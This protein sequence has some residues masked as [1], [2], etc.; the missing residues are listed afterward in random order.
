MALSIRA[1]YSLLIHTLCFKR[2]FII[3]NDGNFVQLW[4]GLTTHFMSHFTDLVC[5]MGKKNDCMI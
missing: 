5:N 3:I 4:G 1:I 2:L